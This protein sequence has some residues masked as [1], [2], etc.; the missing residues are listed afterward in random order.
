MWARFIVFSV[1]VEI[2]IGNRKWIICN[3]AKLTLGFD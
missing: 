2:E 3:T 1:S